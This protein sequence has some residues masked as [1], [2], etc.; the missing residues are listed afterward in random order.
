MSSPATQSA[1]HST[2]SPVPDVA[3][4]TR[5]RGRTRVLNLLGLLVVVGAAGWGTYWFTTGRYLQDTEDA[6]V[7]ADSVTVSPKVG[8]Y[9]E[10]VLVAD[11][12]LVKKGDPL[13]RLD[14]RQYQAITD[15]AAANVANLQAGLEQVEAQI[16]EQ[17]A[18][19]TQAQAQLQVAQLAADHAANEWN[20]YKPLVRTGASTAEQLAQLQN[21]R[22]Q[23]A[24]Q[25]RASQSAVQAAQARVTGSRAQAQ[26]MQAQLKGA[27]ADL[28]R[29][30][31]DLDDTVLRSTL[32]GK[33]GDRGVRIGQLVQPGTRLMSIVPVG[34]V[35]VTANFKET[36]V[37]HMQIGQSVR[38]RVDALP[39]QTFSGEID[40]FSP[41]TGSEFALLPPENATGNFTK[42]VQRVPVRIRFT[43]QP[44][45]SAVIP[46]LSVHA[47][48]DTRTQGHA[49]GRSQ[50]KQ[51]G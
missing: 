13:V 2:T 36:Q 19:L 25:L 44:L 12:Q 43:G 23:A 27:Q 31:L 17:Q 41:G 3:A 14:N 29:D 4:V 26:A 35:Y 50:D 24:V 48:V 34:Q 6:Y 46:G 32:D 39:D 33:V 42:I 7:K 5:A 45:P 28:R 40:S 30:Q 21:S 18:Q 47:E 15:K 11:N 49:Q 20:R 1:A 8:G 22:Q 37:G 10:E 38:L 9:V 16:A 51:H